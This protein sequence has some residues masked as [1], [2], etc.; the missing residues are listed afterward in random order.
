M[1][2]LLVETSQPSHSRCRWKWKPAS[3][4]WR[5][6][7]RSLPPLRGLH[8]ICRLRP[9]FCDEIRFAP[10]RCNVFTLED[11]KWL[12]FLSDHGYVVLKCALDESE[13]ERANDLL[14]EFLPRATGWERGRME[15]WYDHNDVGIIKCNGAGQSE[16]AWYARTRPAVKQAFAKIWGTDQLISAFDGFNVFLPWHHGFQKTADGWLHA[17]QG[18]AKRG[19]QT[20]Q[21]FVAMTDQDATTG[22]LHVIPGSHHRHSDWVTPANGR[23]GDFV[24]LGERG[25]GKELFSLPHRLV[26]CKAGDLVLWDSRCVH[27]NTPATM[28]PTTPEGELLRVAIYVCMTKKSLASSAVLERRQRAYNLG[29]SS[30]HWPIFSQEE[31]EWFKENKGDARVLSLENTMD[32]RQDLIA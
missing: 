1:L 11:P 16:V 25:F 6:S 8:E 32:G 13:L 4:L 15:T 5:D 3:R 7:A 22:G 29:L 17:D 19:L 27:C 30:N 23:H 10:R 14:W 28:Q 2:S 24:S 12:Q 9:Q 18:C 21:G 26:T 20:I 31:F